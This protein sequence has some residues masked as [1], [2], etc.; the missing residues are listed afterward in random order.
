[1]AALR[2]GRSRAIDRAMW[3]S[4]VMSSGA[5]RVG[6]PSV[7]IVAA[8]RLPRQANRRCIAAMA[9]V[10]ATLRRAV[11][12]RF[13]THA[14]WHSKRCTASGAKVKWR[15]SSPSRTRGRVIAAQTP[16]NWRSAHALPPHAPP[17]D[18]RRLL[19][20]RRRFP[21]PCRDR[22]RVL[23]RG[24][25][26]TTSSLRWPTRS[27]RSI[28]GASPG[29]RA[30]VSPSTR[31]IAAARRSCH[32]CAAS[33][34]RP[35]TATRISFRRRR[36]SALRSWRRFRSI[37]NFQRVH[38]G[39]AVRVL[40]RAARYVDR[41]V[42]GGYA[43]RV[44]AVEP[45]RRFQSPLHGRRR[46]RATRCSHAATRP[47]AMVRKPSPCA[48]P[49][50]S[51]G[52]SQVRVTGLSPFAPGLRPGADDGGRSMPAPRSSRSLPSTRRTRRT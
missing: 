9:C 45:A 41:C 24:R 44:P 8:R 28:R 30:R 14:A 17:A 19:R 12:S 33:T 29:G 36:P 48:R 7:S 11:A 43:A 35:R 50:A 10:D 21:G 52:D 16:V 37:P 3:V 20:I 1:M 5:L 13:V 31:R 47:K 26:I 15:T 34:S 22:H 2:T 39:N 49:R 25:S 46:R 23:Q 40:H 27:T 6:I 4:C 51:V 42:P 38:R 18:L 32:R